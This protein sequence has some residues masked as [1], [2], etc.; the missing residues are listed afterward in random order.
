MTAL[1]HVPLAPEHVSEGCGVSWRGLGYA[2]RCSDGPISEER[3]SGKVTKN[4][5]RDKTAAS[6]RC[7]GAE[8]DGQYSYL[9]QPHLPAVRIGR[10]GSTLNFSILIRHLAASLP[11]QACGA[12]S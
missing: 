2:G 11:S 10:A 1:D 4:G 3:Q 5:G 7:S 8:I 12:A 9:D 6:R